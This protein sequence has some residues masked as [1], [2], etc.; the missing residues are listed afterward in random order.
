VISQAPHQIVLRNYEGVISKYTEPKEYVEGDCGCEDCEI[1][2]K[3]LGVAGL[4]DSPEPTL[5]DVW[6]A[7]MQKV[8]D[9]KNRMADV[10][11]PPK[12]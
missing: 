5:S 2:T 1:E 7:R 12:A 3:R 4:F 8:V 11:G 6:A 9:R 10:F